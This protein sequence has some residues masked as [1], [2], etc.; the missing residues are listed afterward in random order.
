MPRSKKKRVATLNVLTGEGKPARGEPPMKKSNISDAWNTLEELCQGLA[1]A[2]EADSWKGGGDPD[3]IPIIEAELEL[4]KL[5]L[6]THIDKMR[7]Y[8]EGDQR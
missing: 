7:R 8:Y 5:K 4:A 3:A 2:Q 1:D 6:R